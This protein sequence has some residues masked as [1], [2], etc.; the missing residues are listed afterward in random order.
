[1]GRRFPESSVIGPVKQQTRQWVVGLLATALV[2]A[3]SF[4]YIAGR[5]A[6]EHM[7]ALAVASFR[8]VLAGLIF[9][10]LLLAKH[11]KPLRIERGDLAAF[12][13]LGF[14]GVVLN[15]GGFTLSLGYTNVPHVALIAAC[16][17]VMVLLMAWISGL[18][19]LTLAKVGGMAIAF[20]GVV[21]LTAHE[22]MTGQSGA[23]AGDLL[24]LI[25]TVGFSLFTV[26]SKHVASR[27]EPLTV[28]AYAAVMGAL[29]SL[30]VAAI[31]AHRLAW[32][33]VSW[34]GWAGLGYMAVVSSVLG[35]LIFYR[36]IAAL[37]ASKVAT[38][39]FLLPVGGTVLGVV[40]LHEP[41]S[42]YFMLPAALIFTGVWLAERARRQSAAD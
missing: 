25:S 10:G 35:Y 31:E 16:G 24:E 13:L 41:I 8:L 33:K 5:V 36:L 23:F 27:Y 1:M 28:A 39:N 18:E 40:L 19:K 4:N 34:E 9:E 7:P 3:W 11:R 29:I 15:Q 42:R 2:L 12:L 26:S 6:A 21:A 17:P 20:G 14:T 30:P 32:G 38:L 37:A 22:H